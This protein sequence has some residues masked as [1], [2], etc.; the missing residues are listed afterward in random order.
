[1]HV[2][3]LDG[4]GAVHGLEGLRVLDFTW[5]GAGPLAMALM[6]MMGA[7]VVKVESATRPDMARA[8]AKLYGW[9][10]ENSLDRSASFND[11]G[12]E[13]RSVTLD[14]RQPKAREL[15]QRLAARA[16][17]I[18]DNMRPG[19]MET[20]GLGYEQVSKVNPR[21]VCCSISATG[22]LDPGNDLDIPGYA[23]VFWAEGGGGSVT[24]WPEGGPTYLRSPVDLN[25]GTMACVGILAALHSRLKT[26]RGAFID[27]SAIE[28]VVAAVGDE[29]MAASLGLPAGGVRGNDRMPYAPNDAFPCTGKD[30]WVGISIFDNAQWLALC[31]VLGAAE[32]AAD[33]ALH[34]REGRWKQREALYAPIAELTKSW[35]P[36]KLEAALQARGVPA[37]Q[38]K[39]L[40]TL[41]G[42]EGLNAR[43]FWKTLKHPLME[44]QKVGA[45]A[46]NLRP[47]M[48][49]PD[50]GGALLGEHTEQVLQE[51]LGMGHAEFEQLKA[52]KLFV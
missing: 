4:R 48:P 18:C 35:D 42:D 50:H 11:L 28:T 8:M 38:S 51:W 9:S 32:L 6:R 49:A 24:G 7:E 43:G 41:F 15:A 39:S 2:I 26:G 23:P 31:E 16:D 44:D 40:R 3:D 21:V 34:S 47:P 12:A 19:K 1:M 20:L 30:Q 22:R 45:L 27:C 25:A 46:W 10:S 33:K 52:E 14:L 13:K 5:A 37:A 36:L 17:V 29:L